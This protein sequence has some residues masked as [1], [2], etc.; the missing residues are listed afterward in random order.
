MLLRT[1][2]ASAGVALVAFAAAASGQ[3]AAPVPVALVMDGSHPLTTRVHL[4]TFTAGPPLCPSG[5]FFDTAVGT[6][7]VTREFT[8]DDGSGVF[9][10]KMIDKIELEHCTCE[11]G[12][13]RIVSGTGA[14]A[15]L[16]GRGGRSNELLSGDPYPIFRDTWSGIADLDSVAPAIGRLRVVTS[17]AGATAYAVRVSFHVQ[18]DVTANSVTYRVL[19]TAGKRAAAKAALVSP[20]VQTVGLTIAAAKNVRR[21]R[22]VITATDPVGNARTVTQLLALPPRS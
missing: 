18:D 21:L 16:R 15:H 6:T 17:R 13:W 2:I 19:A 4:G 12:Q 10:G 5:K 9:I 8:C 3:V 20:G 22:V 14:M 1:L 11:G 7:V